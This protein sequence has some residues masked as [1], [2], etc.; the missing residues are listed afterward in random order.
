MGAPRGAGTT[1]PVA[2]GDPAPDPDPDAALE[3]ERERLEDGI[4]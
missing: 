2:R 1:R 3:A 4:G